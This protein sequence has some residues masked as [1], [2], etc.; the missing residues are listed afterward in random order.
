MGSRLE[1]NAMG[2]VQEWLHVEQRVPEAPH[3]VHRLLARYDS[4]R[5][6]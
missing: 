6:Q 5:C 1:G 3:E 4:Y 2:Q